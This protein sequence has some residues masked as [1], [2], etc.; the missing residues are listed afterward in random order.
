MYEF[1]YF[2]NSTAER[3]YIFHIYGKNDNGKQLRP[4]QIIYANLVMC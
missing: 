1:V 2:Q 4:P 3:H